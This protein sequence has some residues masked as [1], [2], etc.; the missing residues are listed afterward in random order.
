MSVSSAK[1]CMGN[2]R[3]PCGGCKQGTCSECW[4]RE[5]QPQLQAEF[6][7]APGVTWLHVDWRPFLVSCAVCKAFDDTGG[8]E[9]GR[10]SSYREGTSSLGRLKPNNLRLHERSVGH[11]DALIAMEA[12]GAVL[13]Q[14]ILVDDEQSPPAAQF[15]QVMGHIRRHPL[16]RDGVP[17]VAGNH[18][19][20]KMLWCI[21]EAHRDLKRAIWG[22]A[23][24]LASATLYQDARHGKLSL[25]FTAAT[26]KPFCRRAGHL[27]TMDLARDFSL[28]ALGIQAASLG[29]IARL[30]TPRLDPPP[31]PRKHQSQ[32]SSTV[33]WRSGCHIP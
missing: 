26:D 9:S 13:S 2:G 30:C 33:A 14:P 11:I 1:L 17:G 18:K 32:P 20:R 28:D 29:A 27:A 3:A 15:K 5:R 10:R 8:P 12:A 25:R 4:F 7:V 22:Q 31:T 6:E 19:S 23:T 21:A 24:G 16:G